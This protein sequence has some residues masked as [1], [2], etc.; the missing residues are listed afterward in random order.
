MEPTTVQPRWQRILLLS[1]LVYEAISALLGGVLLAAAPD[2]RLMDM[3][4]DILHGV[5]SDFML[6][7]FI[8]SALGFLNGAAFVAVLRRSRIDW[9]LASLALGGLALW[10]CAEIA[11][12]QDLVW[13]HFIW[14]IPVYAGCLAALPLIPSQYARM[15]KN[16][17]VAGILSSFL[18]LA[19]NIVVPALW[20][21]Y[22]SAS[23]TISEL[24]AVGAPTRPVWVWLGILYTLLVCAFGWGIW[25]AGNQNRTLRIAGGLIFV[26]GA[27]GI[28]WPLAPMHLREALAAGGGTISDTLHITLGVIT[29]IIYLLALAFAVATLGKRFRFY[30]I[31]TVVVLILFGYLTFRDSPGIPTNQPTPLLGIWERVNIGA[32]LLWMI[33]L[34]IVLL[35]RESSTDTSGG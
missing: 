13:E 25:K 26:Y 6:P 12:V 1:I 20:T 23:Q 2:G 7:G 19:M 29:E 21:D 35:G 15:P 17:L 3:P 31:A 24:S 18:Y 14:G 28:F 16:T 5:F 33:V 9:I 30:S 8:L 22:H 10:F 4:V 32:F 34:A 27:L 11:I